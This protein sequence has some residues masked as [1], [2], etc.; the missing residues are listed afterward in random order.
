MWPL[1][2]TAPGSPAGGQLRLPAG[3]QLRLPAGSRLCSPAGGRLCLPAD[4]PL[5]R[6]ADLRQAHGSGDDFGDGLIV[7]LGLTVSSGES[8]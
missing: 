6:S 8:R 5:R 1:G 3:G 2:L 7:G 4:G